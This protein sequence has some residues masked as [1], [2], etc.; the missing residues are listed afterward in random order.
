MASKAVRRHLRIGDSTEAESLI[1]AELGSAGEDAEH[2]GSVAAIEGGDNF[3]C[4]RNYV[5]LSSMVSLSAEVRVEFVCESVLRPHQEPQILRS[6]FIARP[7]TSGLDSVP[8]T[9]QRA[10]FSFPMVFPGRCE[11][12]GSRQ[13]CMSLVL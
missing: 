9:T 1:L 12:G 2:T 4:R 8:F 11:T 3:S 13:D 7:R 6:S 5:K 10:P